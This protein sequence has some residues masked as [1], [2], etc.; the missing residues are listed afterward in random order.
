MTNN[1]L[2]YNRLSLIAIGAGIGGIGAAIGAGIGAGIGAA[3]GGIGDAMVAS[4]TSRALDTTLK[5]VMSCFC[6]FSLLG[7]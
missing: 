5:L 2:L 3:I 4:I 7:R 1:Y 6:R